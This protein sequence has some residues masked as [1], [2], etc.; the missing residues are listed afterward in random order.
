MLYIY[1]GPVVMFGTRICNRW[2]GETMA[3]TKKKAKSN[4]EYQFKKQQK[5]AASAKVSLPG[6]LKEK[7][8]EVD[9]GYE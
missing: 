6:V 3:T 1:D 8:T 4:L 9:Y 5:L 2:H 7:E